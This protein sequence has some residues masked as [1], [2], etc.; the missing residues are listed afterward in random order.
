MLL[1]FAAWAPFVSKMSNKF[2]NSAC[3]A[4]PGFT[5][6][7]NSDGLSCWTADHVLQED[8][9]RPDVGAEKGASVRGRHDDS[10]EL[11][12]PG[13]SGWLEG[14]R[15]GQGRIEEEK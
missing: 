14:R 13:G 4:A 3:R 8:E 15:V 12:D 10:A 2:L 7:A 6:C 1:G 11:T 5:G 9:V